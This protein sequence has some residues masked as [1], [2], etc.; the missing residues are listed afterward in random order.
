MKLRELIEEL[1]SLEDHLGCE[2]EDANVFIMSQQSWPFE[3]SI[4][5]VCIRQEMD[6]CEVSKEDYSANGVRASD[7]FIVEGSQIR[8]GSKKAWER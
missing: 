3:N 1:E 7:V 6:Q 2:A 8:Y 4:F 5:R